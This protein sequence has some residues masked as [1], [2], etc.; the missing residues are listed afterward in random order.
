MCLPTQFHLD[1]KPAIRPEPTQAGRS[2]PTSR[3]LVTYLDRDME[4]VWTP[5]HLD[6]MSWHRSSSVQIK[7]LQPTNSFFS[8]NPAT[9]RI[10][11]LDF[12]SGRRIP[13]RRGDRFVACRLLLAEE[14]GFYFP[15]FE[16][17]NCWHALVRYSRNAGNKEFMF[18]PHKHW[19]LR[20]LI[21]PFSVARC[22]KAGGYPVFKITSTE[23]A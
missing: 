13:E 16:G 19:V 8:A 15:H 17:G 9:I 22:I 12:Q 11:S 20:P 3:L 4:F 14:E 5:R 2:L 7:P 23:S 1:E 21:R 6:K 10:D 18:G